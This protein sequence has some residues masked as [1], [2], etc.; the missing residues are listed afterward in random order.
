MR[1]GIDHWWDWRNVG[2]RVGTWDRR[3]FDTGPMYLRIVRTSNGFD[4]QF[5]LDGEHWWTLGTN[6]A[7][8]FNPS[9]FGLV[10]VHW[11]NEAPPQWSQWHYVESSV[12]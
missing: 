2:T 9:Y 11:N 8:S 10:V 7:N 3:T 12:A 6:T 4:G 1:L 5:S